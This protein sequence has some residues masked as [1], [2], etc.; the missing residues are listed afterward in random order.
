MA[1]ET[2]LAAAVQ[3]VLQAST[4]PLTLAKIRS[5]L[6][7]SLRTISPE[8]LAECLRRLVAANVLQPFPKYRSQ[9]ERYWDR[10]MSVHL[11]QLLRTVLQEGP[12]AWSELRRKLPV[13]AQTQAESILHEQVAQG[14][15]HRHPPLTPRGAPRYGITPPDPRDYLRLEL[16]TLFGRMTERFGFSQTQLRTA[17]LELLHE[18]EWGSVPVPSAETATPRTEAQPLHPPTQPPHHPLTEPAVTEES[19]PDINPS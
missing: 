1:A 7:T 12:L 3:H 5:A 18:E 4:E 17:A 10:P 9:H 15:L 19:V 2:D 16:A 13:Y 11:A 14:L 8:E 6:P